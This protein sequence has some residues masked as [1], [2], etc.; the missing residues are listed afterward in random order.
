MNAQIEELHQQRMAHPHFPPSHYYPDKPRRRR[1]QRPPYSA[2]IPTG[3]GDIQLGTWVWVR[4]GGLH[5]GWGDIHLLAMLT[6]LGTPYC[7][8]W[9]HDTTIHRVRPEKLIVDDAGRVAARAAGVTRITQDAGPRPRPL[10]PEWRWVDWTLAE[11]IAHQEQ[12]SPKTQP[13]E[14]PLQEELFTHS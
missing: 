14:H 5:P 10:L 8:V 9:L 12:H 4:P 11:H 2:H 13:T 1:R 3:P 7:E 6:T